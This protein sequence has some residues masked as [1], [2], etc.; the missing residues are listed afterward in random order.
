VTSADSAALIAIG[1]AGVLSMGIQN[2]L[3]R[4]VLGTIAPTTMMTGN[5][6][7][8]TIDLVEF[9]LP[10]AMDA[11]SRAAAKQRLAKV[12]WPLLGF[13]AGAALGSALTKAFSFWSLSVPTAI[14]AALTIQ[15]ALA[16]AKA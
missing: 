11:K 8:F 10:T 4:Q 15:A 2:G 3:M 6:T 16:P 5:L 14:A 12:G 13:V 1:A 9:G 7:Q